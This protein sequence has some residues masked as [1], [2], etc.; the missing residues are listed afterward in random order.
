MMTPPTGRGPILPQAAP[1]REVIG[2]FEVLGK[3]GA[4]GMGAVYRARQVSL[5]RMVALKVL[6]AQ[7]MEDAESVA[8]FQ[9][10]ARVAAGLN[11]GNLVKVYA[12]GEAEGSHYIAMELIEG[13]AAPGLRD[14]HTLAARGHGLPG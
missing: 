7:F 9:R 14:L 2:D 6:P 8:R 11:H 10:E 1:G 5:G 12:A 4:G 3:L 13:G